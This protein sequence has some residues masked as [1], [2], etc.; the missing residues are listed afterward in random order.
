VL[1]DA[2]RFVGRA[3]LAN[4]RHLVLVVDDDDDA[5]ELLALGLERLGFRV[6]QGI[7][8]DDAVPKADA[9]RPD[10][11]V[12]DYAMPGVDGGEAARRLGAH[13]GT[14]SIPILL[15]TGHPDMVPR[16]VR[17]GCAAFLAKPCEPEELGSLLHLIIA[18]RAAR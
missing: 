7:D 15:V 3:V 6:E 17:L 18:A 9:L 5:R 2:E 8:G 4:A 11:I 13:P 14:R 1:R 16:E 12:M 10:V